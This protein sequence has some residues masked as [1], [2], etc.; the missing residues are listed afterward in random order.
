M[1]KHMFYSM[2]L[3][4]ISAA[5]TSAQDLTLDACYQL[6][7]DNDPLVRK[8]D[9]VRRTSQY[10]LENVSKM[11]LPQVSVNGQ[12]TYQSQTIDFS[13]VLG[14]GGLPGGISPPGLSRDQYRAQAEVSQL[15]YDGGATSRQRAVVRANEAVQQQAVEVS[16]YAVRDRVAQLFFSVL[17]MDEQLRQNTLR[18]KDLQQSADK[19]SA[20]LRFGTAF[21]S[22]VD[23][24][25]AEIVGADMT[26][27]ELQS[28]KDA[29]LKM[30]G[31]FIGREI[32]KD[33]RLVEPAN[34]ATATT[35]NRPE[36][37][38]FAFQKAAIDAE[39]QKLRV[40]Y[41]PR[42][43]AFVQGAYGR[44][45]LNIISNTFGPWW[46]AGAR[47]NW[48]L[49]SLYTIRNNRRN[50][51]LSRESLSV[52]QDLFARNIR[53][54]EQQQDGELARFAK[55][56][57]QDSLAIALRE[58]VKKASEA[59]FEQG[60]I[61]VHDLITQVNAEDRARQL[62]ILHRIQ[63]LQAQHKLRYITGN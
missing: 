58:S 40:D 54:S 1:F 10:T 41:M 22:N 4:L 49:G 31:T 23:L 19:V 15:L 11:Y 56:M 17:L 36:L 24:I 51:G 18:K 21:R 63:W 26:A 53:L 29:L 3:V 9:L 55:L 59:Q 57:Q 50:L 60:V 61:T 34:L 28:S 39:E 47:L 46:V 12:A 30:L 14:G 43:S 44:P 45:T 13:D 33:M 20:S 2:L 35:L 32:T 38:L 7:R 42:L 52:D 37:R 8:L 62:L 27:I 48:N 5:G 25:K 6:A 16:L